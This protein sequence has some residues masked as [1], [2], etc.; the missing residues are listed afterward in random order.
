[1]A[2]YSWEESAGNCFDGLVLSL[3]VLKV[4]EASNQEAISSRYLIVQIAYSL[5]PFV[6]TSK[7]RSDLPNSLIFPIIKGTA[8]SKDE[9]SSELP[10]LFP[11][12]FH[13]NSKNSSDMESLKTSGGNLLAAH[14]AGSSNMQIL[15]DSAG[16][17]KIQNTSASRK[18]SWA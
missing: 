7:E 14:F 4:S 9:T 10:N 3:P 8:V 1:M 17:T 13:S 5:R 15:Y 6:G 11:V 18:S 16:V 2:D 12:D